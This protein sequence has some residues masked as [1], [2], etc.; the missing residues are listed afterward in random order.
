MRERAPR[1]AELLEPRPI[2]ARDVS[3]RLTPGTALIEYLLTDSGSVAFVVTPDTLAALDLGV[4]RSDLARLVEFSRALIEVGPEPGG[5]QWQGPL[6]RLHAYLVGPA[7]D[8][9]LLRRVERLVLVPHAELHYVPFAAL[10]DRSDAYLAER[11]SIGFAPSA[12]VWLSLGDRPT[13]AVVGGVLALAPRPD[14]LPATGREVAAVARSNPG[15]A[16]VLR[17][18][19][20]SEARLRLL[21]GEHRVIHLATYGLLNTRNP[22]FSYVDLRGGGGQDG[23]LEVHEVFGLELGADLVVLSACQT[24]LGSGALADVPE[25]DDWVGLTRAFL[26]AGAARVAATLWAVED[27][28]SADL[29]ERFYEARAMGHDDMQA[30]ATAQRSML[31]RAATAHP[32]HWAGVVIVG[33]ERGA[34]AL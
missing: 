17:G 1:R 11:Y 10:M 7:E 12:S 4:R 15:A 14:A 2:D 33:Q 31:Q 5:T 28:S 27:E 9:G 19:E 21:A 34:D 23:R 18:P 26:H 32:F 30:L 24:A 20:A 25:G 16:R 3:R 8:A 29:M 22:L 13:S 6:R